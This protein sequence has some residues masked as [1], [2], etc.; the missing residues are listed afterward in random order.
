LKEIE[1]HQINIYRFPPLSDDESE[2][3]L[4]A[5]RVSSSNSNSLLLLLPLTIILLHLSFLIFFYLT[6]ILS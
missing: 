1:D 2:N 4:A 3:D 6:L 5:L